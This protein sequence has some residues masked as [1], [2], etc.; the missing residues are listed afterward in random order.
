MIFEKIKNLIKNQKSNRAF[1]LLFAVMLSSI[2]LSVALGVTNIAFKEAR[3]STSAKDSNEAFFASDVGV[4]CALYNDKTSINKFPLPSSS[5]VPISSCAGLTP[6]P[7]LSG[8]SS[9]TA[10]YSFVL[11]GLANLGNACAKVSVAK[12]SSSGMTE[13]T[14]ISKGYNTGDSACVSTNSNRVERELK[15]KIGAGGSATIY[16]VTWG[17]FVGNIS[18]S[19]NNLTSNDTVSG[20]WSVGAV[21]TQSISSGDGYVEFSTNETTSYKFVGL[22]VGNTN[23]DYSDIEYGIYMGGSN[24]YIYESGSPKFS[25]LSFTTG[26]I[27]KVA[28]ESGVVKYYKNGG[29][30]FYTSL[31]APTYPLLLDTSF[32]S[33]AGYVPATITNAKIS[34]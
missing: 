11:S 3:F 5:P 32:Y 10:T 21:S 22:G 28:V 2:I 24:I 7:T 25:G 30:P 13:T 9:T 31:T 17:N 23:Q 1:V 16:D 8:V 29:T 15:V 27:F 12:D 33:G 6:T 19:G 26:D 18:A 14:I 20:G 4:E 34:Y